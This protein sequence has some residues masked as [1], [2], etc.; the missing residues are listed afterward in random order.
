MTIYLCISTPFRELLYTL[1]RFFYGTEIPC[2]CSS[3]LTHQQSVVLNSS[4]VYLVFSI[5]VDF[6][7]SEQSFPHIHL[8]H[9]SSSLL[10]SKTQWVNSRCVFVMYSSDV[11]K[12]HCGLWYLTKRFAW[13]SFTRSLTM[14][15]KRHLVVSTGTAVI[16]H[17]GDYLSV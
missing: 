16:K 9:Y 10:H 12:D 6:I 11:N 17:D 2:W 4:S 15:T 8:C 1:F 5:L 7:T 13:R 14:A 3:F